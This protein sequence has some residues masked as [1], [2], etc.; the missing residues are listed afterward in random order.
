MKRSRSYASPLPAILLW[1]AVGFSAGLLNG[2]LGAAGGIVLVTL[3]PLLPAPTGL[4]LSRSALTDSR[5]L[6]VTSLCVMLPVTALSATLY[7]VSGKSVDLEL[8]PLILLPAALGGLA[9]GYLLGKIP[10]RLLKKL[11]GLLVAVSGIRMLMG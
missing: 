1:I 10:R 7:W 3:L 9:G 4:G 5:D 8:A 11:F 6:L 2:L